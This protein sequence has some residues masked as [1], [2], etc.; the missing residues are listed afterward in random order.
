VIYAQ[1]KAAEEAG[2]QA[3]PDGNLA[4]AAQLAPS[5]HA[6]DNGAGQDHKDASHYRCQPSG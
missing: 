2:F 1:A 4:H 6:R 5:H 3:D